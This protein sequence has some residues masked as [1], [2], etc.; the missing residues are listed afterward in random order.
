MIALPK[1]VLEKAEKLFE[2]KKIPQQKREE[3][4]ENLKK[5]YKSYM[6]EPGEAIGIV[7]AQSISEPA[8]QMSLDS[9]ERI[10]I[11]HK[12]GIKIPEI[13]VFTDK[14]IEALGRISHDGWDVCDLSNM[15]VSVPTINRDEKIEWKRVLACS[16]HESPGALL[17]V[18]TMSGREITATDSHSFVTRQNNNV[19][20]ISGKNLTEGA[21]TPVMRLLPENCTDFIDLSTI[22]NNKFV[23][24]RKPLP[25]NFQ[26]DEITGW[27]FG[28]YLS[29]GNATPNFV[30]ISNTDWRFLQ[31]T[32]TFA[33]EYGLTVNEY[34]NSR[35]FAKA[36]D[37]R[38]NS[39]LLSALLSSTCGSGSANKMVPEFAYSANEKFV[40]SLLQAYFEGDGNISVERGAIRASS[41]SRQLIGGIALLL[42][43]FGIFSYKGA[44]KQFTLLVPARYAVA[45][46]EKI[47]FVTD[48]KKSAL[49]ELCNKRPQK[50]D[51]VELVGGFGDLLVQIANK[52][53]YPARYVNSFTRRQKIGKAALLRYIVLFGELARK[54]G[55]Y[56]QE[57]IS[58]LKKMYASDVVWDEVIGISEVRPSS[59]YVYDLTVEGTETF[60]TFEGIVTHNTMRS[61]HVA[62]S[63][64]IRVTLGLP[65]LMEIFD[66]RRT[67]TTPMMVIYLDKQYQTKEKAR[68]IAAKIKE[69]RIR[70]MVTDDVIDLLNAQIEL[71]FDMK[72]VAFFNLDKEK[73]IDGLKKNMKDISV[74]PHDDKIY[75]IP[76][77]QDLSIR[78]MQKLKSKVLDMHLYGIK[79]VQ[80][81]VV[82]KEGDEW[83][84]NTLGSN[85][86]KVMA[87]EGVDAS[88]IETND[89]HE[90]AKTLG[91]EAAR[92]VIIKEASKTLE[93]QGLE[94]DIRHIMIVAD[95]MT[96][97]GKIQAIGRYGVAGSKGSVLARAAFEETIKH[98]TAASV[99]GRKDRFNGAIE[100]VMVGRLVP[101]G[102]GMF[103]LAM[104]PSEEEKEEID[105]DKK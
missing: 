5:A 14:M 68:D 43:R 45:F 15:G 61:Y 88:R 100:N 4:L 77:K 79:G 87:V 90:V 44:G 12:D 48:D 56:I 58:V 3:I 13:G 11:K 31:K 2:E 52:L 33:D 89:I 92:T 76:K 64:G 67:P 59:K 46:R 54:K 75:V 86:K 47:G 38:I 23:N 8:T 80:Q 78:E 57:E 29:E 1:P 18:R 71:K 36:H 97:T 53:G 72:K 63:A 49:D 98:L 102:T 74:K 85:L 70:E 20:S 17:K 27:I 39:A 73:I 60:T 69:V 22:V 28:A 81:V 30:N 9:K 35:G 32:K 105:K 51:F 104:K 42:A 99:R 94:V 95:A 62:G 96:A 19:V 65:R 40:S 41:N 7:S 55:L 34:D 84:L 24:A 66:A 91:I 101:I 26:L 103:D 21:R 16:R 82:K 50:Q 93:E 37:M 6:Y 83:V 10:I 25:R